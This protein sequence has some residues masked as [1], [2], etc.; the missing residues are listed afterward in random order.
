MSQE[1]IC[2]YWF[3]GSTMMSGARV[4][5]NCLTF[6]FM[7]AQWLPCIQASRLHLCQEEERKGG[8]T[9]FCPFQQEVKAFSESLA[10]FLLTS[11]W[12]SLCPVAPPSSKR[13]GK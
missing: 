11:P 4:S 13:L 8:V 2:S 7:S 5:E 9:C 1:V 3:H 10:T 12:P 6:S